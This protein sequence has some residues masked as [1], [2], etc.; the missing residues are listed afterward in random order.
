MRFSTGSMIAG[1]II[2]FVRILELAA[3]AD[4]DN[5]STTISFIEGVLVPGR[6]LPAG[7]YQFVLANSDAN[8]DIVWI[9]NA[10]RTQL[11]ATIQTVP[12]ERATET[13][14]TSITLAQRPG[15]QPD[16]VV[17]WFYPGTVTGHEFLYSKQEEK[18]LTQDAK[19]TLVDEH[20]TMVN[21]EANGAG[22]QTRRLMPA[23]ARVN[24][25]RVNARLGNPLSPYFVNRILAIM[26]MS[27]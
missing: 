14:G 24:M 18:E 17:S 21:S 1:F 3:H 12:T 9:F 19:E 10:D 4:Q 5:Q 15:G 7:T 20:G 26:P 27:S 2:A 25:S 6:T 11:F 22:N 13:S 23:F 8:R 16:A